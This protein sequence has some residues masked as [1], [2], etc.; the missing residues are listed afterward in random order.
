MILQNPSKK[1]M[2]LK[3]INEKIDSNIEKISDAKK[4]V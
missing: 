3:Q 2:L 1:N 4:N